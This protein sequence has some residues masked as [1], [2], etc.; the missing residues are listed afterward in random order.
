MGADADPDLPDRDPGGGVRPDR[1]AERHHAGRG[2]EQGQH[3]GRLGERVAGPHG[4]RPGDAAGLVGFAVG[5]GDGPDRE[6]QGRHL[7]PARPRLGRGKARC[8]RGARRPPQRPQGRRRRVTWPGFRVAR[9]AWDRTLSRER[10]PRTVGGSG[11]TSTGHSGVSFVKATGRHPGR[12]AANPPTTRRGP[13]CLTGLPR[14]PGPSSP[15]QNWSCPRAVATPGPAVRPPPV[16]H[17]LRTPSR[18]AGLTEAEW[19][20]GPGGDAPPTRGARVP[21]GPPDGEHVAAVPLAEPLHRTSGPRRS[22]VAERLRPTT[23]RAR[24]GVDTDS[25]AQAP[26]RSSTPAAAPA[27]RAEPPT[28]R[29]RPMGQPAASRW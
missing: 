27:G 18:W 15:L 6:P 3:P 29:R 28:H 25:T 4:D 13:L 5:P 9:F 24:L 26:T 20:R 12:T 14:T 2:R 16:T 8:P 19:I 23:S 11:W 17:V 1:P 7:G 22:L 10:P 21:E